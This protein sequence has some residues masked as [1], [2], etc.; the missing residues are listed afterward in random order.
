MIETEIIY[1]SKKLLETLLGGEE[2]Q[3]LHAIDRGYTDINSIHLLTGIPLPCIQN[4]VKALVGLGLITDESGE[5][6][7]MQ[8]LYLS[9]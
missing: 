4:K 8:R 2:T 1:P 6:L 3:I 5:L 7:P 9:D